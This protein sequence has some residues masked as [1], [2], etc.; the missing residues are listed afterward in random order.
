MRTSHR[1]PG[2]ERFRRQDVGAQE[3]KPPVCPR[4]GE[5]GTSA[6]PAGAPT[7][8][9]GRL[10]G[11]A[12]GAHPRAGAEGP[13]S[14][15][16]GERGPKRLP[17]RCEFCGT[18]PGFGGFKT[19]VS[20]SGVGGPGVRER[21]Q[22]PGRR[23][24]AP[25]RGRCLYPREAAARVR[26][27]IRRLTVLKGGEVAVD[28]PRITFSQLS[29]PESPSLSQK[30][31]RQFSVA[32][33][34]SCPHRSSDWP[35]LG[36]GGGVSPTRTAWTEGLLQ[37]HFEVHLLREEERHAER[38]NGTGVLG[39]ITRMKKPRPGERRGL[40]ESLGNSNNLKTRAL[41]GVFPP[42]CLG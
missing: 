42:Y 9:C 30:A 21:S 22:D 34:G 39:P 26:C 8:R 33:P 3:G 4:R 27:F 15:A 28:I 20:G 36:L 13:L 19:A 1:K 11:T 29:C 16:A 38:L 24:P 31:Q 25:R 12:A 32:Q 6:A 10:A 37:R 5:P 14:S 17:A 2:A 41:P 40:P 18:G 35:T 7:P 23:L